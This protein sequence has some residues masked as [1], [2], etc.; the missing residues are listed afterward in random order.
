MH[1]VHPQG[2]I[3][4]VQV[5]EKKRGSRS[6]L[7]NGRDVSGPTAESPELPEQWKRLSIHQALW[8]HD[9]LQVMECGLDV[10]ERA[11]A[12]GDGHTNGST[13]HDSKYG[14]NQR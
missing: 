6:L 13:D 7:K 10:S 14:A 8:R 5:A 12:G 9:Y 3:A 2:C 4:L 1:R 11:D